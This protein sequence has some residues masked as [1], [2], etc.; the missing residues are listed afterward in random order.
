VRILDQTKLPGQEIYLECRDLDSVA[1]AIRRLSVRGA[2]AIGVVAALALALEARKAQATQPHELIAQLEQMCRRLQATRPTAVNLQWALARMMRRV[3]SEQSQAVAD[4]Q[5]VLAQEAQ[6][7]LAEDIAA[8]K[9]MG[10][11]G[12]EIVPD[13]ATVITICNTGSLATA[14]HG[15]ALGVIRSAV[16]Q[17]KRV[18]VVA[19]ETRPLLQ[20]ARLTAWELHRDGIP[21]VLITDSMAGHYMR[22]RGADLVIAGADRIAANG[23]TANKIGTYT[24]AVLAREHALP[25][26]IAA[27]LATVDITIDSG[28]MIPIEERAASEVTC[29]A[30]QRLAPVQASVWNPAFDVVPHE[31][32]SGIITER[33]ILRPPLSEAIRTIFAGV[34]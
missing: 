18:Q 21:F 2:P 33:G 12:Q 8:N 22:R 5:L 29:L 34:Q 27:P 14:G 11:C 13:P 9:A 26:Y 19:C 1:A 6:R 16:A 23:D 20:G 30:G 32:I 24:L 25:F 31:Y 10:A 17:G 4:L 28:D 7:I 15:T 3:Q